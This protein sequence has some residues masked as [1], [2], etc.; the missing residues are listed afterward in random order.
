VAR[1]GCGAEAWRVVIAAAAQEILSHPLIVPG[2][3]A[4]LDRKARTPAKREQLVVSWYLLAILFLFAGLLPE[5]VSNWP[6]VLLRTPRR[7][8]GLDRTGWFAMPCRAPP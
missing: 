3:P 2:R 5:P 6:Y 8:A 7:P 1:F 4:H